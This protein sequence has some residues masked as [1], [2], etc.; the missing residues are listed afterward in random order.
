MFDLY[1]EHEKRK[2][3][4]SG[5]SGGGSSSSSSSSSSSGGW[6]CGICNK[7]FK[8]EH[9]LDLHL[10]RKHMDVSPAPASRAVCLADHCEIFE[11]CTGDSGY[12]NAQQRRQVAQTCDD[13]VLDIERERCE[14][15]LSLCLPLTVDSG[16][17]NTQVAKWHAK[18]SRDYCQILRCKLREERRRDVD[19]PHAHIMVLLM[20]ILLFCFFTFS[21]I[22]CCVENSEDIF[23]VVVEWKIASTASVA[24]CRRA[25]DTTQR[26]VGIQKS[27][28]RV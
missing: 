10:E 20:M 26:T 2:K 25:R 13:S 22:V 15:T 21:L 5:R 14:T 11:V 28:K 24:R 3:R 6:T 12:K 16:G 4:R 27:T 23:D 18:L 1:G 9:Y 7:T 17:S 19:K 8:S